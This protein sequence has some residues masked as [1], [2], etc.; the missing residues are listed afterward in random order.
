MHAGIE[1]R[2]L[3]VFERQVERLIREGLELRLERLI[4]VEQSVGG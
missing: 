3:R 1:V 4:T 2:F